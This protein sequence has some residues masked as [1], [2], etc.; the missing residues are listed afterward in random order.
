MS[1]LGV[2]ACESVSAL[3]RCVSFRLL[4]VCRA[5]RLNHTLSVLLRD[6]SERV[7][8]EDKQKIEDILNDVSFLSMPSLALPATKHI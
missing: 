3:E 8:D 7:D 2:I 6:L 4:K 5:T 1:K